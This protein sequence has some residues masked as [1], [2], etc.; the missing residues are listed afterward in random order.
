M[1]SLTHAALI[2]I[3]GP[4]WSW[5]RFY[6]FDSGLCHK[7]INTWHEQSEYEIKKFI[8]CW[9]STI[10]R[11]VSAFCSFSGNWTELGGIIFSLYTLRAGLYKIFCWT[12]LASFQ[13][14][15]LAFTLSNNR[16]DKAWQKRAAVM[17]TKNFLL[18]SL[19][20]SLTPLNLPR[21]PVLINMIS[22]GI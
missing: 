7:I 4:Y 12:Q 2:D 18:W 17:K 16:T 10:A 1:R 3:E 20:P 14:V 9:T 8:G 13:M 19:F 15:L 21:L 22:V 6:Y 11:E 5:K